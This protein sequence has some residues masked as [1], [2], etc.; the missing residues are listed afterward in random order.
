MGIMNEDGQTALG[1][2][3]IFQR[4]RAEIRDQR[5]LVAVCI[6][7]EIVLRTARPIEVQFRAVPFPA[8]ARQE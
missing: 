4:H 8:L 7:D 6:D 3:N 1:R 2:G 5:H